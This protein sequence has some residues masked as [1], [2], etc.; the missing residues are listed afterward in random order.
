VAWLESPNGLNAVGASDC[1]VRPTYWTLVIRIASTLASVV[2]P[3][4]GLEAAA[5]GYLPPGAY[6]AG[7]TGASGGVGVAMSKRTIWTRSR[8]PFE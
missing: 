4:N 7:V 8:L 3:A 2:A 1:V 6:T 5:V